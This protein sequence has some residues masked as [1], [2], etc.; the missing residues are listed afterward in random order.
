[1]QNYPEPGENLANLPYDVYLKFNS[2]L[3]EDPADVVED[4]VLDPSSVARVANQKMGEIESEYNWNY[5]RTDYAVGLVN[6]GDTSIAIPDSVTGDVYA[7]AT[8]SSDAES[9]CFYDSNNNIV[10]RW[11][12]VSPA[13]INNLSGNDNGFASI[14]GGNKIILSKPIPSNLAQTTAHI[15]G[16]K[17]FTRVSVA[18]PAQTIDVKPYDLLVYAVACQAALVNPAWSARYSTILAEYENLLKNYETKD[19]DIGG[20]NVVPMSSEVTSRFS[21]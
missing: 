4:G 10:D 3:P 1:M 5:T 6:L 2:M 21:L 8:K 9:V 13:D 17:K 7:F 19:Q 20:T 12:F 11:Q 15:Y 16:F 14:I 18:N